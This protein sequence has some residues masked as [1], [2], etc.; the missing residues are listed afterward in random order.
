MKWIEVES[1]RGLKLHI[2]VALHIQAYHN[3]YCY[4]L[5]GLAGKK[6]GLL[7][8][9]VSLFFFS[10]FWLGRGVEGEEKREEKPLDMADLSWLGW[11]QRRA[12]CAAPLIDFIGPRAANVMIL[13][14]LDF[15]RGCGVWDF[16]KYALL[17]GSNGH[18]KLLKIL[19]MLTTECRLRCGPDS[20]WN[21][22]PNTSP[23]ILGGSYIFFY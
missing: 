22:Y 9:P 13:T 19:R 10:K 14:C 12:N 17:K 2:S 3:L 6:W 15:R 8:A 7:A 16:E 18:N 1:H 23:I 20:T 11:R 5:A 21:S 4:F